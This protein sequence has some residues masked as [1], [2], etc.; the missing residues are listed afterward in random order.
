MDVH[1]NKGQSSRSPE[2]RRN[3][4]KP[5]TVPQSTGTLPTLSTTPSHP[6]TKRVPGHLG[7]QTGRQ[8]T[9]QGRSSLLYTK[10]IATAGN[11][12]IVTARLH[13]PC[14]ID[15]RK[16]VRGTGKEGGKHLSGAPPTSP[17]CQQCGAG[18]LIGDQHRLTKPLLEVRQSRSAERERRSGGPATEKPAYIDVRPRSNPTRD[19][20]NRWER[21]RGV[22]LRCPRN[23][24]A[25]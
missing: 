24:D 8:G 10:F 25:E 6:P 1:W 19:S 13:P 7:H 14:R 15:K 23:A 3:L 4:S 18:L 5:S 12:E 20:L 16:L 9:F 17:P 2:F 22:K 11:A 21:T